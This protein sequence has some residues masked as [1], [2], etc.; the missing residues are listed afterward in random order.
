MG[1]S[2]YIIMDR[3]K[4]TTERLL[5]DTIIAT[6]HTDLMLTLNNDKD[7]SEE[8]EFLCTT[9]NIS[10]KLVVEN[11]KSFIYYVHATNY[12][13]LT[14]YDHEEVG[15]DPSR[16]LCQVGY[17]EEIYD[18]QEI[19]FEFIYEYLKLNPEDYF[20]I[21]DYDWVYSWEDMQHLKSLPYD[22][23]W[24]YKNPKY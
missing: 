13:Y 14:F 18:V 11:G 6:F 17:I 4:F 8:G 9:L 2:A 22:P 7:Y 24:C 21:P 23:Q 5:S 20:W 1:T 10:D 15:L 19:I 12:P 16:D 3:K